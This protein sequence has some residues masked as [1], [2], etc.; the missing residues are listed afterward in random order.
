MHNLW[1]MGLSNGAHHWH[2]HEYFCNPEYTKH[3]LF[4]LSTLITACIPAFKILIPADLVSYSSA[5]L[6]RY[7]AHTTYTTQI[8]RVI[9]KGP[10]ALVVVMTTFKFL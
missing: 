4:I 2:A 3:N 10:E 8:G 7:I 9:L 5:V 1:I 6:G